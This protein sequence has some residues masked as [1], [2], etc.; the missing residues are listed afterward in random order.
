MRGCGPVVG[1]V[2]EGVWPCGVGV[3]WPCV[4]G[5]GMALYWVNEVVM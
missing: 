1:W 3:V 2:S 5:G 4:W